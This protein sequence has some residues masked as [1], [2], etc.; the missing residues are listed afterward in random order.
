MAEKEHAGFENL[1]NER[2]VA[3]TGEEKHFRNIEGG[4]WAIINQ[5][6]MLAMK[7]EP[8]ALERELMTDEP[9]VGDESFSGNVQRVGRE[10]VVKSSKIATAGKEI[11]IKSAL[12][13]IEILPG[14]FITEN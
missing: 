6:K 13:G 12:D 11:E 1:Q 8:L 2:D 7:K 9:S 5:R 3:W 4:A 14:G 10:N